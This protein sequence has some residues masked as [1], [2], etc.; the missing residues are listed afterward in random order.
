MTECEPVFPP[1]EV[2]HLKGITYLDYAGAGLYSQSHVQSYTSLLLNGGYGN[3][4][5][6]NEWGNKSKATIEELRMKVLE[7]FNC[8]SAE[9]D[10]VLTSGGTG[11]IRI[12]AENFL[13]QNKSKFICTEA[14]HN[15]ILGIRN[16]CVSKGGT[17]HCLQYED[18]EQLL[19]LISKTTTTDGIPSLFAAPW[20]CNFTGDV[21]PVAS[22]CA[23]AHQ[24]GMFTLIDA[25]AAFG[26]Y[27]IDLSGD[28]NRN[29]DFLIFSFYKAFGMPT[30]MGALLI[31]K[32]LYE[33]NTTIKHTRPCPLQKTYFGGGTL[34][35]IIASEEWE[36]RHNNSTDFED[37]T[38]S[39]LDAACC[40][41][42]IS[43][44][45]KNILKINNYLN[46]LAVYLHNQMEGLQFDD[47]TSV[48]VMY[49]SKQSFIKTFSIQTS[50]Q[51]PIGYAKVVS[52]AT[53]HNIQL[54]GG[55]FCNPGA[56]HKSLNISPDMAKKFRES[57]HRCGD[58]ND[59]I[60]NKHT[61][62]VRASI[63][64]YTTKADIDKF[65]SF[66]KKCYCHTRS[67]LITVHQSLTSYTIESTRVFPIKGLSGINITGVAWPVT[68]SGF[69]FDRYWCVLNRNI[70]ASRKTI[71]KLGYIQPELDFSSNNKTP[72]LV[73]RYTGERRVL[74]DRIAIPILNDGSTGEDRTIY[75]R[76]RQNRV[77]CCGEQYSCWL[78]EVTG[79]SGLR[80]CH[81]SDSFKK[82]LA[83]TSSF[84]IINKKS[85][86]AVGAN[87]HYDIFRP[88]LIVNCSNEWDECSWRSA[89]VS[90][91]NQTADLSEL[92]QC[93]RCS[94][95]NI[96]SLP[97]FGIHPSN[98]PLRT[99]L[100]VRPSPSGEPFFGITASVSPGDETTKVGIFQHDVVLSIILNQH[101]SVEKSESLSHKLINII[102]QVRDCNLFR[103]GSDSILHTACE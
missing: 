13:F 80:L 85:V 11:G 58:Q 46:Y 40:V 74:C 19:S 3:P 36:V 67:S 22:I 59:I 56:C 70:A 82:T 38:V 90:N 29:P 65:I 26:K 51:N 17:F 8:S 24:Q 37:G 4:H 47:G 71:P 10:V 27:K 73:L 5:S 97:P 94:H 75:V 9:Y 60:N 86:D 88:N 62:A 15:S 53:V 12:I 77:I 35:S 23:T 52:A 20:A 83:N 63:G 57:G 39:Y 49:S 32:G 68:L 103:L 33:P 76:G 54:R 14:N 87:L 95:V 42:G 43:I 2:S 50:N 89:S 61:G 28:A 81:Q 66:L 6:D 101:Q 72:M 34:D 25:C 16:V 31:K 44:L 93:L 55:C 92:S 91:S 78:E 21:L 100:S 96:S 41:I 7:Y 45:N 64:A 102:P 79:V 30:G 98:E 1:T 84:L 69:L 18:S 48:C 99:I